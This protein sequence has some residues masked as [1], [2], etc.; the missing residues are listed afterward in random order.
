MIVTRRQVLLLSAA[1]AALAVTGC[2]R[3]PAGS[4]G[5]D[6]GD[7][8]HLLPTVSPDA[9][10]IKT[11]FR[12]PLAQV[13]RLHV[14][15]RQVVGR[16]EDSRGRFFS[17]RL[18][19]LAPG[20][21]HELRLRDPEGRPLCDAWP[22][23]TLPAPDACPEEFRVASFTCAG[24]IDA[25]VLPGGF[26][27][28][29]PA[30][31]R[32]RI[33]QD[34][35]AARPDVVIANGDHVYWDF[36]SWMAPAEEGGQ[37]AFGTAL[38]T[39][40]GAFDPA[41]PIFGAS[42]EETLVSVGDN[43][44]A[45]AYGVIF[46]STPI[47]CVTDDHDYFDN[48]DATP[49][50]VTL[51]PDP[52]HAS[53]RDAL[54]SLYLPEFIAAPD[55]RAA[56]PGIFEEAGVRLS[57]NFGEFRAGTLV[58]GLLYDC[59]GHLS[60]DG[61]GGLVP[62]SVEAWLTRRTREEDTAHLLHV[63]SHP[64]GWTAGKWREWYP[65][66]LPSSGSRLAPVGQTASGGKYLWQPGWWEQHQRLLGALSA[67]ER[68]PALVVSGDLHA[69]GVLELQRSGE[70]DLRANPVSTVLTGPVGVGTMGWPSVARGVKPQRPR[71][72]EADILLDYEESIGTTLLNFTPSTVEWEVRRY[73]READEPAALT[74]VSVGRFHR[75]RLSGRA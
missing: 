56:L 12:N 11:S 14:A 59:G 25:P 73:G 60:L 55:V 61:R 37:G 6:A 8:S 51:P 21:T 65:D 3:R 52:F 9:L 34:L 16:R 43:Q 68:R 42:N 5:W 48:D 19:G 33:F 72:L 63:P 50:R 28:F 49:E 23:R 18:R 30:R 31:Y 20:T 13:P 69:L 74:P 32:A 27:I 35:V 53:L 41:L 17:F 22:L 39:F 15:G 71:G 75:K 62:A 67:Q 10:N 70:L 54:Q 64:P 1:G 38:E 4:E 46:R 2:T 24:G 7:L 57:R 26:H 45:N 36:P 66:Y 29:K 47:F 44:I 40:F 58:R